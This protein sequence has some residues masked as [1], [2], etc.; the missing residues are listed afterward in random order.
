MT[1]HNMKHLEFLQTV[2]N[3]DVEVL[4]RKEATY[5]GSWKKAGGRSAWFMARR[6]LDR[7]LTM[8]AD[9][10]WPESF[11]MA[12]LREVAAHNTIKSEYELT[13]ELAGWLAR[14]LGAEDIFAMIEADPSGADGTVLAVVRDARRY[15]TLVEAEMIA[16]GVVKPEGIVPENQRRVSR[17]P[18]KTR[19]QFEKGGEEPEPAVKPDADGSQHATVTPWAVSLRWRFNHDMQPGGKRQDVFDVWWRDRKPGLW[20]LEPFVAGHV[21][22]NEL[23][24]LYAPL[25]F[26][27]GYLLKIENCPPDAREWFPILRRS[28]L[29]RVEYDALQVWQRTLYTEEGAGRYVLRREF[30]AW[31]EGPEETA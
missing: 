11:S 7:L 15:F 31:G 29:N 19:E 5:Q 25:S 6:N 28:D 12:D 22:P 27:N 3:S 1:E 9:V 23:N 14:K 4:R 20:V 10:P 2:A 24:G 26:G 30:A 17:Y 8:M 18:D 16:R 21:P 13:P